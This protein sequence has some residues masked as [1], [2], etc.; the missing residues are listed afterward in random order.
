MILPAACLAQAAAKMT[1]AC[2]WRSL[3]RAYWRFSAPMSND[4]LSPAP[5]R[6]S[7]LG[8]TC[9]NQSIIF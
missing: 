5:T 2:L 3:R 1:W 6:S 9:L 8:I 4:S 7:L